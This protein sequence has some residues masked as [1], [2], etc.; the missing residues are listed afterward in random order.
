[1]MTCEGKCFLMP[2][3]TNASLLLSV[4][5]TGSMP[6]ASWHE[7]VARCHTGQGGLST[8][9]NRGPTFH[10]APHFPLAFMISLPHLSANSTAMV[11]SLTRSELPIAVVFWTND[12]ARDT[13]SRCCLYFGC[14]SAVLK[15]IGESAL[16]CLRQRIDAMYPTMTGDAMRPIFRRRV[17]VNMI[18]GYCANHQR[19]DTAFGGSL[20]QPS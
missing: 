13:A 20:T 2:R 1:M 16:K 7:Y 11:T 19:L 10:V 6:S 8:C 5:V 3:V 14:A 18:F 15:E 12:R 17:D 9:D 4:A